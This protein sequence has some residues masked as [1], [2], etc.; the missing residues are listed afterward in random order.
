MGPVAGAHQLPVVEPGAVSGQ[1]IGVARVGVAVQHGLRTGGRQRWRSGGT[2]APG[3]ACRTVADRAPTA[4]RPR[5]APARGGG[6]RPTTAPISDRGA[7]AARNAAAAV[8]ACPS[9][10]R[11]AGRVPRA[12]PWLRQVERHGGIVGSAP[13]DRDIVGHDDGRQPGGVEA[14]RVRH[15]MLEGEPDA[16][17]GE[18]RLGGHGAQRRQCQPVQHPALTLH[19]DRAGART[20][21]RRTAAPSRCGWCPPRLHRRRWHRRQ[22]RDIARRGPLSP[23]TVSDPPAS[24]ERA[25]PPPSCPGASPAAMT[26]RASRAGRRERGRLPTQTPS[27]AGVAAPA[28]IRPAR[29]R[30]ATTVE[31]ASSSCTVRAATP[32]SSAMPAATRNPTW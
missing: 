10:R 25:A 20:F 28:G 13:P 32:A 27:G 18:A 12:P 9:R 15:R 2:A 24:E 29:R 30:R 3:S 6:W 22:H 5:G 8:G 4:R 31:A 26:I 17:V 16:G 7:T 23:T 14:R 19:E 21:E 11:A 1:R